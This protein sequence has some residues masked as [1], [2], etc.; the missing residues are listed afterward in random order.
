MQGGSGSRLLPLPIGY[1]F[2]DAADSH[3]A[4]RPLMLRNVALAVGRGRHA[5]GA[6]QRTGTAG[7]CRA[8]WIHSG[9]GVGQ[10]RQRRAL[11]WSVR[12]VLGSRCFRA[13]SSIEDMPA[14][15]ITCTW[16][17][18]ICASW[19]M[20][21]S[22]ARSAETAGLVLHDR[23]GTLLWGGGAATRAAAS[24]GLARLLGLR[25]KHAGSVAGMLARMPMLGGGPHTARM[26]LD[27]ALQ[28]S[29]RAALERIGMLA[30]ASAG[31]DGGRARRRTRLRS[32]RL[33]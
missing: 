6:G 25:A 11:G 18:D 23:H 1:R 3:A 5:P 8:R 10:Q 33:G 2:A 17:A 13:A 20:T 29:S 7:F 22:P 9:P 27:L 32:A 15:S 14:S 19:E 31:S 16:P 24:A 28:A 4:G 12:I 21:G 30:A 26:A